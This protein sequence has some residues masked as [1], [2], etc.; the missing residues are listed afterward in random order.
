[1]EYKIFAVAATGFL[2]TL[3]PA[4]AQDVWNIDASHSSVQFQVRHLMISNVR[5]IRGVF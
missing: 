4:M 5:A 1:M 2:L 3:Q